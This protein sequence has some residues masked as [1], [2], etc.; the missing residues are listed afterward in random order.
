MQWILTWGVLK[1]WWKVNHH[2]F[3]WVCLLFGFESR[4]SRLLVS[5]S[6]SACWCDCWAAL[7]EPYRIICCKWMVGLAQ[8]CWHMHSYTSA[9]LEEKSEVYA[10]FA[11]VG[12]WMQDFHFSFLL[13]W[14]WWC[15]W[16]KGCD[17]FTNLYLKNMANHAGFK[18][19]YIF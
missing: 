1:H 18:K 19:Q 10:V 11:W 7:I 6:W 17:H 13:M 12:F 15:D 16:S 5:V 2:P 3:P 14:L 9:V 8:Q 4:S